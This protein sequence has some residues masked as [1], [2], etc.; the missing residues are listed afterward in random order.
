MNS[1]IAVRVAVYCFAAIAVLSGCA[2]T[3]NATPPTP[4]GELV[5]LRPDVHQYKML[6]SFGGEPGGQDPSGMG[7]FNG[8]L[9]GTTLE[10]GSTNH[11]AVFSSS[12]SGK[13]KVIYS[14]QGG[15]DGW[16]PNGGLTEF[17]GSFYGVTYVGGGTSCR[18]GNGCGTVYAIDSSGKERVVYRFKPNK[19]DGWFPDSSLVLINGVLYGAT[20]FGYETRCGSYY[21]CGRIFSIDSAGKERVI[22]RFKGRGDGCW[23][24]SL[25][26]FK[27]TIYGVAQGSGIS[28]QCAPDG[29]GTVFAVTPSGKETVLHRF[30]GIPDGSDPNSL[31][32]ANGVLYGTTMEGG[33]QTCEGGN[34][35]CGVVFSVTTSGHERVLYTFQGY[36][37]GA[38]PNSLVWLKG[39]LYG[40]TCCDGFASAG[41][42]GTIFT[43]T[44]SR[45]KN[46][47]H[48]FNG[49]PRDGESPVGLTIVD[50]LF[51]GITGGGGTG[52]CASFTCG[53]I[54][55]IAP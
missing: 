18:G 19:I 44:R 22:Y 47:L 8:S 17:H 38:G 16:E 32:E 27:G 7:I 1:L 10:G 13:P 42:Y 43:L 30:Q 48:R 11:G 35:P 15:S 5:S 23:P 49:P 4:G 31:I 29:P 28:S 45:V 25:L 54:F 24:R 40:T 14:F 36:A 3:L 9:Y 46:T 55:R 21:G 41:G 53:T 39:Q 2:R 34:R 37:D 52:R 20:S 33:S 51:Y 26:A 6:Y 12:L 50:G